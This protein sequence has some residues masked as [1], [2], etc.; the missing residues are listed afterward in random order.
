MGSQGGQATLIF[1]YQTQKDSM[2]I[3]MHQIGVFLGGGS[4]VVGYLVFHMCRLAKYMHRVYSAC[5]PT[6]LHDTCSSWI[7]LAGVRV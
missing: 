6:S 1:D 4:S 3:C 2:Q 7:F 5:E